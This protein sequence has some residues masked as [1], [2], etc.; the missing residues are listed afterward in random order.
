MEKYTGLT[1]LV[2]TVEVEELKEATLRYFFVLKI[3]YARNMIFL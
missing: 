2:G 1:Y 3:I